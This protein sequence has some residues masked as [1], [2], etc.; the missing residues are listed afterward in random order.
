LCLGLGVATALPQA[1]GPVLVATISLFIFA[2]GFFRPEALLMGTLLLWVP[3]LAL[4]RR[5]IPFTEAASSTDLLL[6]AAPFATFVLMMVAPRIG[7]SKMTPLACAVLGFN[8]WTVLSALNP[9]R[10]SLAEW[11]SDVVLGLSSLLFLLVPLL[12]FWIGR[13]LVETSLLRKLLK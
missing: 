1:I 8:V 10:G 6:L 7:F 4:F 11:L 12:W 5:L 2:L 9:L 3:T 13:G